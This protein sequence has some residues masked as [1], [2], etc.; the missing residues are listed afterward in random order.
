M[1]RKS[2]GLVVAL[3][4]AVMA[5]AACGGAGGT[6]TGG[7]GSGT[8]EDGAAP[9]VPASDATVA[10]QGG[11]AAGDAGATGGDTVGEGANAGNDATGAG[12]ASGGNAGNDAGSATDV[13]S[14]SDGA[15]GSGGSNGASGTTS[16][17][18]DTGAPTTGDD[19]G[20]AESGTGATDAGTG[21]DAS[22]AQGGTAGGAA[23]GTGQNDAQAGGTAGAGAGG[24]YTPVADAECTTM[25]E[26]LAAALGVDVS[27]ATGAAA[28][29][30]LSGGAGESCQLT[31]SGTGEQF[32]SLAD[33]AQ[34]IGQVFTD[35]G[36]TADPQYAAD[37]PTG[38]IGGLRRDNQLA[39]YNVEWSPGPAASCPADQPVATCLASLSPD[40]VMYNIT[41][42]LAQ[43]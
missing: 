6:E 35:A 42:D 9:N 22:G 26:Q 29:S 39:A 28:F 13:G 33:A 16:P 36:W 31:I 10:A 4:V 25:Q 2:Y 41:V 24:A 12:D 23:T 38:T 20:N 14:G 11:D 8:T 1:K 19:T 40:Q 27:R 32:P 21:T 15:Q 37:G 30:D 34:R 7:T 17:E 3:L 18:S 5:L 43:Q